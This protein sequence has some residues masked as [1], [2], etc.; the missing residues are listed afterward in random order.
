MAQDLGRKIDEILN[1]VDALDARVTELH[2][3]MAELNLPI[4][5]E[6]NRLGNRADQVEGRTKDLEEGANYMSKDVTDLKKELK[7]S[8]G[9]ANKEI[10]KLT[11]QLLNMNV[12]QRRD[13]LRFYGIEKKEATSKDSTE[14]ILKDF[15]H[16]ELDVSSD[17]WSMKF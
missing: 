17:G 2:N 14:T 13:N 3:G 11:L 7:T 12:Y 5:E 4:T 9:N 8:Y 15:L 1:K 6:V 10:E 16:D